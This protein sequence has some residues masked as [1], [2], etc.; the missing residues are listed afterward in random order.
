MDKEERNQELELYYSLIE[1]V[2]RKF[3]QVHGYKHL[4]QH[5]PDLIG[6]G[7]V[8]LMKGIESYDPNKGSSKV[9]WYSQKIR[10]EIMHYIRDFEQGGRVPWNISIDDLKDKNVPDELIYNMKLEEPEEESFGLIEEY[11]PE[12]EINK[13]IYHRILMGEA[14]Q[15]EIADEFGVSKKAIEMRKRKL[16]KRLQKQMEQDNVLEDRT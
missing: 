11:E 9:S 15:R 10:S 4:K 12:D 7:T 5:A 14:T 8:G 2:V 1:V 3:L 13:A 16:V 6:E